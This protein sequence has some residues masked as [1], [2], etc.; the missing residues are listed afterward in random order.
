[1]KP[2][3]LG[4]V[5]VH[6]ILEW[7]GAYRDPLQ[8]YPDATREIVDRHRPWMEPECYD[9]EQGRMIFA[10]QSFLVRTGRQT[11]LIDTC[12]GDDKERP[13]R[14]NWHRQKWPWMDNLRAAGV[15]PED[16]DIVLCTHLHVDHVGWNTKLLDGR[17]VPTFPNA[18]YIFG[19]TE[20]EHWNENYRE[21][22]WLT[23]SYEDSVIP[24]VEAKQHL[25]VDEGHELESGIWLKRL[26]ATRPA[27]CACIWR[28][29]G[30]RRSSA[31]T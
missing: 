29:R 26:P 22:D 5:N 7:A 17:W 10:F 18:K 13:D 14:P 19:R 27:A 12:V 28:R 9:G 21:L 24:I 4:D 23:A 15:T 3:Q 8:M 31:V 2:R 11:I 1:M 30:R 16:I 6:A 20:F 25:L